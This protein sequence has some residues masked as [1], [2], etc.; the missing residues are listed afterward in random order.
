MPRLRLQAHHVDV[1]VVVVHHERQ[2]H[3]LDGVLDGN[4]LKSFFLRGDGCGG[5]S[6]VYVDTKI[7]LIRNYFIPGSSAADTLHSDWH[8]VGGIGKE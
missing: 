1:F 5:Y 4:K 6:C 2:Q 3:R 8:L 7:C